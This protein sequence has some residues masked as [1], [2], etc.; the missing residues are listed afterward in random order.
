MRADISG[1]NEPV[2]DWQYA[3]SN[4]R[5]SIVGGLMRMEQQLRGGGWYLVEPS[6]DTTAMMICAEQ[7]VKRLQRAETAILHLKG[8][9]FNRKAAQS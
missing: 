9:R 7:L 3:G 8:E 4:Y 5:L 6:H 2:V 1:T